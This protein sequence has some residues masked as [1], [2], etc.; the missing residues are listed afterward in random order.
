MNIEECWGRCPTDS[1]LLGLQPSAPAQL[2]P[3]ATSPLFAASAAASAQRVPVVPATAC[4]YLHSTRDH[5]QQTFSVKTAINFHQR[6]KEGY[7]FLPLLGPRRTNWPKHVLKPKLRHQPLHCR[8][9]L[10]YAFFFCRW[11]CVFGKQLYHQ[12]NSATV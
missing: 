4:S 8:K 6:G 7:R 2:P 10:L 9:K 3:P 11:F 12:I 1:P 5:K